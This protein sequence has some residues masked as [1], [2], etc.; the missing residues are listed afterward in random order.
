MR[1]SHAGQSGRP[2]RLHC[3]TA[4]FVRWYAQFI[5][6][7]ANSFAPV[8][9]SLLL[10]L[11]L[12][13][14]RALLLL[15]LLTRVVRPLRRRRGDEAGGGALQLVGAL[16]AAAVGLRREAQ[17]RAVHAGDGAVVGDRAR[18]DEDGEDDHGRH[19]R[20]LR[21]DHHVEPAA[22]P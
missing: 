21:R 1:W 10:L 18:A 17:A 6:P 11:L 3:T 8:P 15:L 9:A 14:A 4:R 12:L 5:R 20:E 19:G 2:Q 22:H 16:G 7:A 13:A